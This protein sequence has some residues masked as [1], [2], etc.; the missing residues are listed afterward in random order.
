MG[1]L[2]G[3]VL[4]SRVGESVLQYVTQVVAFVSAQC[5]HRN[6]SMAWGGV[7]TT[8]VLSQLLLPALMQ[9]SFF[10]SSKYM[11]GLSTGYSVRTREE[12]ALERFARQTMLLHLSAYDVQTSSHG[13]TAAAGHAS[14][15]TPYTN[16][17]RSSGLNGAWTAQQVLP[18]TKAS[19]IHSFTYTV[20]TAPKPFVG[21]DAIN[22]LRAIESWLALR[23][24]PKVVFLGYAEGYDEVS[25][26][27]GI[28]I[29]ERVDT[30]FAGVPLFNS[31]V[32]RANEST[33]SIS[34]LMNSDILLFDD[35]VD[36]L[37]KTQADYEDWMIVGARWDLDQLPDTMGMSAAR[38]RRV[39]VRYVRD[40]GSLHT[41]GGI[42][43]WAWNTNGP[44]LFANHMPHFVYGRGKYDNWLTHEAIAA[45]FRTVIDV[46]E[47][48][49][50]THVKHDYHLVKSRHMNH[51]LAG[52]AANKTGVS[53]VAGGPG[54]SK[55][56]LK[57][58][59]WNTGKSGSFEFFINSYLAAA[60]GSYRNQ[61][62]TILHAP[63]KIGSCYEKQAFCNFFRKRPHACRCEYSSLVSS[64]QSDAYV[65]DS[66]RIIC[67][68]LV[69]VGD[70][71]GA[72]KQQ[73]LGSA[74]APIAG[75]NSALGMDDVELAEF[76]WGLT[77]VSPDAGPAAASAGSSSGGGE[78]SKS[79]VGR[80]AQVGLPLTLRYLTEVIFASG[81]T[82]RADRTVV[83]AVLD[84]KFKI[85]K[86]DEHEDE[87]EKRL[88]RRTAMNFVCNMRLLGVSSFILVALNDEAYRF[89]FVRGWPVFLEQEAAAL[90]DDHAGSAHA[91]ATAQRK[92][93]ALQ[94]RLDFIRYSVALR[95]LRMGYHV[96]F[97]QVDTVWLDHP[98]Q[99]M[100]R[101]FPVSQDSVS[102]ALSS[103]VR[104]A[105][106]TRNL[107]ANANSQPCVDPGLMYLRSE[108]ATIEL[109]DRALGDVLA[110]SNANSRDPNAVL[111]D[112]ACGASGELR[113]GTS[114]CRS[115][116]GLVLV[117]F[118]DKSMIV[119][120]DS[121]AKAW[122]LPSGNLLRAFPKAYALRADVLHTRAPGAPQAA[123]LKHGFVFSNV[124]TDL[125]I[126]PTQ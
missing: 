95:L 12:I 101:L 52:L 90:W 81:S 39:L 4:R 50:L 21:A 108:P 115:R 26:K 45:G 100:R 22:Q 107:C 123:F 9:L 113:V 38:A 116:N 112:M 27:Y 98:L 87:N 88:N 62:G 60:H 44:P 57:R 40:F 114:R 64:T 14:G 103:L 69:S 79:S 6:M 5:T 49:T 105:E 29:D 15:D 91:M 19:Q 74:S 86:T 8:L 117:G 99:A 122:S 73:E 124:E 17:N 121:A 30:N 47:A 85:G 18:N 83:V 71:A 2:D 42:D 43:L 110:P 56:G 34:V 111:Q 109:L 120:G 61:M 59:F 94:R 37:I 65:I 11:Q 10:R 106:S 53:A 93:A 70:G 32:E 7:L 89:A 67:C 75:V 77:G 82:A 66:G 119:S 33:A 84:G 16:H 46:S 58:S 25:T 80:A 97:T 35:F 92:P 48:C 126:Y 118:F 41:Y 68:G 1:K 23:P 20:Y 24:K 13:S 54:V 104:A 72:S 28:H 102:L 55:T 63:F 125:C 36:V 51:V 78:T 3:R 31:M 76:S 96:I